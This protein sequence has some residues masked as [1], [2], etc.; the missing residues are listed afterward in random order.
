[1]TNEEFVKRVQM[2]VYES[3]IKGAL[4]LLENPPGRRPSPG[5]VKLSQWFNKLSSEDREHVRA[6]IQLAVGNAVFGMLVVL[7]GE[8]AIREAGEPQ[9]LL[10]LRYNTE[11]QSVLLN[12]PEGEPLH[13]IFCAL[14]PFP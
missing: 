11:D 12:D 4:S 7:D 14:V 9:G 13:D 3:T 5:L 1:M 6:A 2:S 8:R 10:E